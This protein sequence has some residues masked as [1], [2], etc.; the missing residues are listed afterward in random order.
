MEEEYKGR[1]TGQT[2]DNAI[3][4]AN[5][6]KG[7][8]PTKTAQDLAVE[9]D[10]AKNAEVVGSD[11]EATKDTVTI[12]LQNRTGDIV[13]TLDL[14]PASDTEA[15]IITS[16]EHVKLEGIE[17]GAQKN[18]N[19]IDM[20]MRTKGVDVEIPNGSVNLGNLHMIIGEK[21][22]VFGKHADQLNKSMTFEIKN[23]NNGLVKYNETAMIVNGW[24][25]L[26]PIDEGSIFGVWPD[27]ELVIKNNSLS[28]ARIVIFVK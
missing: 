17:K 1:H 4:W 15:G 8:N 16:E 26:K 27:Y 10:R 22:C 20:L 19:S 11:A 18:D 2:I 3:S 14:N 6:H 9:I 23:K 25:Y 24:N 13:T 21:F 12:Q 28:K 7:S 5:T